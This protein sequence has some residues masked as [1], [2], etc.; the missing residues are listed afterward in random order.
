MVRLALVGTLR[1]AQQPST[2]TYLTLRRTCCSFSYAST[3]P[4]ARRSCTAAHEPLEEWRLGL[5]EEMIFFRFFRAA[6]VEDHLAFGNKVFY[7]S[8]RAV[9]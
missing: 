7:R 5:A 9:W 2:V 3:V 4:A 6:F 8:T 1:I